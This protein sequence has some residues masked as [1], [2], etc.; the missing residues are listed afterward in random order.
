MSEELQ[1]QLA[2]LLEKL[3]AGAE[4]MKDFAAEQLPPLVEEIIRL[5]RVEHTA[6]VQIAVTLLAVAIQKRQTWREL[7]DD[8]NPLGLL[9]P[10]GLIFVGGALLLTHTHECFTAWAAPRLYIIEWLTAQLQR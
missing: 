3:L 8:D 2:L 1:K 4:Q 9:I 10:G 5:G 6:F 7:L